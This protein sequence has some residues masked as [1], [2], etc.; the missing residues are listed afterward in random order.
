MACTGSGCSGNV[1]LQ[2]Q[3]FFKMPPLFCIVIKTANMQ[4]WLCLLAAAAITQAAHAQHNFTALV[5]DKASH[6]PLAGV[7]VTSKTKPGLAAVTDSKGRV[8]L[9]GLPAGADTLQFSYTGYAVEE[10]PVQLPDNSVHTIWLSPDEKTLNEVVVSSTRNNDRIEN[11]TTKVE[12]LGQEE[13]NEESMVKPGNIASILGDISGVQIQQ[14]SATN[15]NSSIRIQGLDGR[16]TQVLRDG[17]PLYDGFSGGFGIL[18]IPPLDLKQLELIKGAASTLYGGGAIGG[19][20]N[21]ISKKP[22]YTPDASFVLNQSTLKETNLNGYYAQRWK[23]AGFTFFAGQT[24]QKQV[25]VNKDGLSDLPRLNSTLLHPTLFIYPSGN[26]FIS[27]GWSGS[28]EK[29][30]GGDMQAIAGK[31]DSAHPY[32][33]HNNI[34]RNTLTLIAENRFSHAVTGTL[35]ASYSIFDRDITASTYLFNAK[36]KSFYSEASLVAHAGKHTLVGGLNITSDLFASDASTPAPVG[37]FSN[38]TQGIFVQDTWQV[39][40]QTRL[41]GGMR[42]DHHNTYGIFAL[43]RLALFHHFSEHWGTRLGFGMGYKTPNPL[44]PQVKDYDLVDILPMPAGV[45]AEKSLGFNA[46]INYKKNFGNE[47]SLFINHA[48]FLTRIN[49]PVVGNENAAGQL[50][51]VNE[52]QPIVTRGFDTYVQL[53]V[54]SWEFYLGYTFTD[55]RRK[56]LPQNQ[57]VPIT[58]RNRAASTIVYEIEGLWRFGLEASYNGPQYRDGDSKTRGYLFM[59]AMVEK[60]FGKKMSLVLNC[61]NLLDARQSKYESLYTGSITHPDFKPLWAP[62]DGRVV[63]LAL[64]LQPFAK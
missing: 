63:N 49:N 40:N 54:P 45:T 27:L 24:F 30:T 15:G 32:F 50:F 26:S 51:F 31:Q 55:A 44:T 3:I 34:H 58:P 36:Q 25:D 37:R 35:K 10:L 13:M 14:S 61:E 11:A 46:E 42:V 53:A 6:E 29:R 52:H 33:E 64:R 60:K 7:S 21:F 23:H 19:L 56:Y 12:V 47:S 62:I 43:P 9:T 17:M 8:V 2:L 18:S 1:C 48:F 39:F 20:V 5:Q 28:F 4:K 38:T 16:Y 57:F 41:E 59:A 22:A